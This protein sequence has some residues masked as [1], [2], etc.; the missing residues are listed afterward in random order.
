MNLIL[1][2]SIQQLIVHMAIKLN[3]SRLNGISENCDTNLTKKDRK[4]D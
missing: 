3:N 4:M 2:L 1:Y